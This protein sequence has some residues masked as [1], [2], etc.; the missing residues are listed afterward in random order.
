MQVFE[1]DLVTLRQAAKLVPSNHG[2][3][4][5]ISTI[6]R[7]ISR[8]VGGVRL[9]SVAI[10]GRRYTSINAVERFIKRL[11]TPSTGEPPAREIPSDKITDAKLDEHG[12]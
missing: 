3:S 9:E 1:E 5:H 2:K 6:H 11:S 10:G 8:G 12:L 4:I 7:W